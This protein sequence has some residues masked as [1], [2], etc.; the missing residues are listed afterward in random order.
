[1]G[2]KPSL[3]IILTMKCSIFFFF[4]LALTKNV[5]QCVTWLAICDEFMKLQTL[6]VT[7][8]RTV[9]VHQL[10]DCHST[11]YTVDASFLFSSVL[12]PVEC[13]TLALFCSSW[14]CIY[15]VAHHM[16]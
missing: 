7:A 4:N 16:I 9:Y 8:S 5:V 6:N 1:M 15:Y 3:M 10:I 2:F 12:L 13:A 11:V 14:L